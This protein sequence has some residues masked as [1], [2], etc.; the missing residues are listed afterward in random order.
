M[1][2]EEYRDAVDGLVRKRSRGGHRP[3]NA[4]DVSSVGIRCLQFTQG[5]IYLPVQ[6]QVAVSDDGKT[7]VEGRQ[8]G[9]ET[10]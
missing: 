2:S 5:G 7:F 8:S 6:V 3:W 1:A 10:G 9:A 4:V